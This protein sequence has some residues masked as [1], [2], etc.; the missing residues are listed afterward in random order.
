MCDEYPQELLVE[1]TAMVAT[2]PVEKRALAAVP[3]GERRE[4]LESDTRLKGECFI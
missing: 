2:G 4:G 1:A 3:G